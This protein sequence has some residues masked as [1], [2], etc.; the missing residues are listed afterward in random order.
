MCYNSHFL[1]LS[2]YKLLPPIIDL[3]INTITDINAIACIDNSTTIVYNIGFDISF[4]FCASN[5]I[6]NTKVAIVIISMTSSVFKLL[7]AIR[8]THK[9]YLAQ[10]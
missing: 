2:S 4:P 6:T 9:C 10:M 3:T 7:L 8:T 5:I 1:I